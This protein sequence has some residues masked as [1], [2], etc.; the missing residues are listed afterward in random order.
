VAFSPDSG[1]LASASAEQLI[2]WDVATGQKLRTI[3]LA[4]RARRVVFSP[5]GRRLAAVCEG[6][7]VGL[8]DAA[9]GQELVPLQISGGELWGV[10]F[11][12]DGRY[13]ASCSGYKGRGTIQIWDASAWEK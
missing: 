6:H 4:A 5:D 10:A 1:R 7:K 11:S 12:P 13:L 2:L 3:P 8:W 9:T